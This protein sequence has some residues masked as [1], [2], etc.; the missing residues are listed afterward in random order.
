MRLLR[1]ERNKRL[2]ESDWTQSRDIS[3]SNDTDWKTYRQS[4]RDLPSSTT[5]KLDTYGDLDL[6]SVSWPTEPS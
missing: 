3:L 2:L 6:T 4:L 5:P 1:V